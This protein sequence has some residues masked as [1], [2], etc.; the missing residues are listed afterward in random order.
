MDELIHTASLVRDLNEVAARYRSQ[1]EQQARSVRIVDRQCTAEGVTRS[2]QTERNRLLG[3]FRAWH[4]C[5]AFVLGICAWHLGSTSV[6]SGGGAACA[7]RGAHPRA[8]AVRESGRQLGRDAGHSVGRL[9]REE[10]GRVL[11]RVE[12]RDEGHLTLAHAQHLPVDLRARIT[13][14]A[15]RSALICGRASRWSASGVCKC[16][17]R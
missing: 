5:M 1:Q 10:V 11:V 7:S 14:G 17:R 12:V 8:G 13:A 16:N 6:Q 3:D 2:R 9:L 15:C 4:S